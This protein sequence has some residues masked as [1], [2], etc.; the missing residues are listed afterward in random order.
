MVTLPHKKHLVHEVGKIVIHEEFLLKHQICL[1][2]QVTTQGGNI[3]ENIEDN[4]GIIV[5]GDIHGSVSFPL[6]IYKLVLKPL[7]IHLI[8]QLNKRQR[9]QSAQRDRKMRLRKR[10]DLE[11]LDHRVGVLLLGLAQCVLKSEQGLLP[12]VGKRSLAQL[13]VNNPTQQESMSKTHQL[14]T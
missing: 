3:F 8:D 11:P 9:A 6:T 1:F 2:P 7:D 10:L 14:T 12:Q 4:I 13:E 5:D